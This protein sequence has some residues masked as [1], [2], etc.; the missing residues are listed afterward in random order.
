MT[1]TLSIAKRELR[2]YFDSP[3]AYVLIGGALLVV[4]LCFFNWGGGFWQGNRAS[5]K[6]MFFWVPFVLWAV[7]AV[8]TMGLLAQEKRSG[9]LEMLIT[10]P[11]RDSE[12]ILGKFLGAWGLI[13]VLIL[14]TAL[15]PLMMF[16][17]PWDLGAID[18]GPVLA[19]YVGLVLYSAATVGIGL[20]ISSLA[21][22]QI[23]AL[24]VT[25][26]VLGFLQFIGTRF[27]L[28]NILPESLELAATFIG[29]DSRLEGFRN[30][31]VNTR[32][33]VYFV[34]L[35]AGCLIGSFWALERRK[36]A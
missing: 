4:G 22:S 28:E 16:E 5:L 21:E 10:L 2:S 20:L 27:T 17:T 6:D 9:T 24:F 12:I 25:I 35:T 19:G 29:F 1:A 34:T 36:W 23:V 11:V 15:Y 13:L 18:T 26:V 7:S 30:G 31:L 32:D 14:S 8:V 33:V 3:V